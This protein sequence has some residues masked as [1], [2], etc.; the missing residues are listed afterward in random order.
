MLV[1]HLTDSINSCILSVQS[2]VTWQVQNK[3]EIIAGIKTKHGR[4]TIYT[5]H[6][7]ILSKTCS[8]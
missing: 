1:L 5:L 7:F 8:T 6:L 4:Q 3:Q 2:N